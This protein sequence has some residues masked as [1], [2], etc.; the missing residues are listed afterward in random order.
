MFHARRVNV[1]TFAQFTLVVIPDTQ[2]LMSDEEFGDPNQ[3][4]LLFNRMKAMAWWMTHHQFSFSYD[5]DP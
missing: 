1:V 5:M 2:K 3:P 4:D